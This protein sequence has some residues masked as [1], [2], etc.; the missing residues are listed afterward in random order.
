MKKKREVL[1][2]TKE[3]LHYIHSVIE[4][5][6]YLVCPDPHVEEERSC[7]E[8]AAQIRS[9]KKRWKDTEY[10]LRTTSDENLW[11]RKYA[12]LDKQNRTK[13]ED[14]ELERLNR[15]ILSFRTARHPDDDKDMQIIRDAAK[16]LK[17]NRVA[18]G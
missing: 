17:A 15:K 8:V 6:A 9:L 10:V 7:D 4:D 5:C 18:N 3:V 2:T 1:Y 16:L 14:R 11:L 13:A 12:L